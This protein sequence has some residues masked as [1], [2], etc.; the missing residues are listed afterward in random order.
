LTYLCIAKNL[1]VK[2]ASLQR[3]ILQA[4][5]E[6]VETLINLGLTVLQAKV[7][8]AL[9]KL[10][11]STSRS[12]AKEAKVA[13]QDVYR[14]LSELQETG[15]V[16]KIIAKPNMYH[17]MPFA[18]GLSMLL[19]RRKV[20]TRE[21]EKTANLI[22]KEFDCTLRVA[23]R[24]EM[25]SFVLIQ[26]EEPIKS[27]A[28]ELLD[29]AQIS[30]DLMHDTHDTAAYGEL[31]NIGQ[32][33]SA[34]EIKVRDLVSR[35]NQSLQVTK[36]FASVIQKYPTFQL[37]YLDTS[38][39]AKLIIKDSK[40]VLVSTTTKPNG[41]MQAFLWSDNPILVQIIQQWFANVWDRSIK[42]DLLL[43]IP[44]TKQMPVK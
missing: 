25:G 44:R 10:G 20:K 34:K 15:L 2:K 3:V 26:K 19:Q 41:S 11:T 27:K 24:T 6:A 29:T 13:S 30:L 16:E 9:A 38:A 18:K 40:E 14:I 5:D 33:L 32:K 35:S 31:Y 21:L 37:R 23:E 36:A 4:I 8:I 22:S 43:Q 1:I 7:Y 42:K 28:F 12:T 39:P 17:A